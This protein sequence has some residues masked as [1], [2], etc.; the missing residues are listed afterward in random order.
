M[1]KHWAKHGRKKMSQK[2]AVLRIPLSGEANMQQ[3]EST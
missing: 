2:S 1:Y 3:T